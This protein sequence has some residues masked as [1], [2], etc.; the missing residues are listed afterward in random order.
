MKRSLLGALALG[1]S[2]T[3]VTH[4][5]AQDYPRRPVDL[6]VGFAA[7]STT[8]SI[9]RYYTQAI[10]NAL[11]QPLIVQ[12]RPGASQAA[13][14]NE[15]R[16]ADADGHTIMMITGSAASQGPGVRDDLPYKTLEDFIPVAMVANASGVFV[17]N[18]NLPFDDMAGL[19]A[20][21][22]ENPGMLN[23]GSSGVGSA[24]HLQ[25]ELLKSITGID[26][27]H[28]PY[29]GSSQIMTA[30]VSGEI[31]LGL[32]PIQGAQPLVSAGQVRAIG[33]TG[34]TPVPSMPDA[35]PL[36]TSTIPGLSVLDPYT[37]YL[38]VAPVGTPE[39]VVAKLHTVFNDVSSSE[40]GIA[41]LDAMGFA[42]VVISTAEAGERVQADVDLWRQFRAD[43]GFVWSN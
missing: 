25:I 1:L 11:G 37:Y 7:G 19:V 21:A 12:N 8:D 23:Y 20:Y 2:I 31:D 13:A 28:V 35:E 22:L 9:A 34:S 26:M 24:S 42:P 16:N 30:L 36:S 3:A 10:A 14:V 41:A 39:A 17:S 33:V 5:Q 29:E 32:S 40:A 4:A 15:L 43:T 38:I 27:A 18:P 6:I